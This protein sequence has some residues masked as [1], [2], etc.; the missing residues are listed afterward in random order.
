MLSQLSASAETTLLSTL[1]RRALPPMVSV[2]FTRQSENWNL[3]P[4]DDDRNA[5]GAAKV[6]RKRTVGDLAVSRSLLNVSHLSAVRFAAVVS[7]DPILLYITATSERKRERE[8]KTGKSAGESGARKEESGLAVVIRAC[9]PVICGRAGSV[10]CHRD[11]PSVLYLRARPAF[12]RGMC[13]ALSAACT[14]HL[15]VLATAK[16]Y[17]L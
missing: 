13:N 5:I 9:R 6:G 14:R 15:F 16:R 3:H 11:A 10:N 1:I 7:R 17:T 8:R 12:A 2:R 4:H